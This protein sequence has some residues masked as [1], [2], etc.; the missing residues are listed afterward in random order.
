MSGPPSASNSASFQKYKQKMEAYAANAKAKCMAS[1]SKSGATTTKYMNGE[2]VNAKKSQINQA[3]AYCRANNSL[4]QYEKVWNNMKSFKRCATDASTNF[5]WCNASTL[6]MCNGQCTQSS[7][8]A[9]NPWGKIECKTPQNPNPRSYNI[10]LDG[11]YLN[12]WKFKYPE[13]STE[14]CSP[15]PIYTEGNFNIFKTDGNEMLDSSVVTTVRFVKVSGT[16][17]PYLKFGEIFSLEFLPASGTFQKLGRNLFNPPQK[18]GYKLSK[19][20][21]PAGFQNCYLGTGDGN[22][23]SCSDI[24][25]IYPRLCT[26]SGINIGKQTVSNSTTFS[27]QSNTNAI[28]PNDILGGPFNAGYSGS[29]GNQILSAWSSANLYNMLAMAYGQFNLQ[30]NLPLPNTQNLTANDYVL[31]GMSLPAFK[32]VYPASSRKLTQSIDS[33]GRGGV[34]MGPP[35]TSQSY[36]LCPTGESSDGCP[37][38]ITQTGACGSGSSKWTDHASTTPCFSTNSANSPG[39]LNQFG[40]LGG[41]VQQVSSMSVSEDYLWINP[42]TGNLSVTNSPPAT[43]LGVVVMPKMQ[44]LSSSMQQLIRSSPGSGSPLSHIQ[45]LF[46]NN[47]ALIYSGNSQTTALTTTNINNVRKFLCI[48]SDGLPIGNPSSISASELPP[49]CTIA[50]NMKKGFYRMGL[51]FTL[52]QRYGQAL[53]QVKTTSTLLIGASARSYKSQQDTLCQMMDASSGNIGMGG[54]SSGVLDQNFAPPPTCVGGNA[55]GQNTNLANLATKSCHSSFGLSQSQKEKLCGS[56]QSDVNKTMATL[57]SFCKY[58]PTV[59]FCGSNASTQCN[60]TYRIICNTM[61]KNDPGWGPAS[62]L[63]KQY[64]CGCFVTTKKPGKNGHD[65]PPTPPVY[66]G[67]T[68]GPAATTQPAQ[69]SRPVVIGH[70]GGGFTVSPLAGTLPPK[71]SKAVFPPGTPTM[72]WGI[73]GGLCAF[74]LL[75]LYLI[76]KRK[77]S[78]MPNLDL[79]LD[80]VYF[81]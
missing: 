69:T 19:Y 66:G 29:L 70:S 49:N 35:F 73:F 62:S 58:H 57:N 56:T 9:A 25:S 26:A 1:L 54:S 76:F 50:N 17:D 18:A 36:F 77:E 13:W 23:E 27:Q 7:P 55:V 3:N 14:N 30:V 44:S 33:L 78:E 37:G 8:P 43:T 48:T 68:T 31:S 4:N 24:N 32:I 5:S 45:S 80:T 67:G 20:K 10:T 40:G 22:T 51:N 11:K 53:D 28:F 16:S 75:F 15:Q 38:N 63:Y 71:D 46:R 59:S 42:N 64:N 2:L 79:D 61:A 65:V 6:E 52:L 60:E 21:F 39:T 47:Y 41:Y 72:W 74:I 81:V 12:N 34:P